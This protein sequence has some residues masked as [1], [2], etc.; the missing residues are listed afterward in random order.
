MTFFKDMVPH[1]ML[2]KVNQ[3]IDQ[4]NIQEATDA[5]VLIVETFPQFAP[6]YNVLGFLYA[7]AFNDPVQSLPCYEKALELDSQYAP[8]YFNL[9]VAL[10]ATGNLNRIPEIAKKALA[11]KGIDP[12]KIFYCL[13]MMHELQHEFEN[14]KLQFQK[15]VHNSVL[16]SEISQYR[17]AFQRCELK[18]SMA[19]Q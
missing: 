3:S 18:Q 11:L 12:G 6:A 7:N 4:N 19:I 9:L 1:R 5:L 13:G 8:T 14:A 15:A 17:A 10:N 2:F 16:D